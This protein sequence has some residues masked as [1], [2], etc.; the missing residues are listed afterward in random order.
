MPDDSPIP[1]P[2][3]PDGPVQLLPAPVGP[4]EF[5]RE[6]ETGCSAEASLRSRGNRSDTGVEHDRFSGA[7]VVR[8]LIRDPA[9][10]RD[11]RGTRLI[12]ERWR[13]AG[14]VLPESGRYGDLLPE[15]YRSGCPGLSVPAQ[16]PA[17]PR[18]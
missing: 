16:L 11:G 5:F 12:V 15:P 2:A 1:G 7:V 10:I 13:T 18:D 6:R 17:P 3:V 14:R 8:E 4:L 9:L